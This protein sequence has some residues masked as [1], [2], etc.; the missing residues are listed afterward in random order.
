MAKVTPCFENG[1]I[2]VASNLAQGIGFGSSELFVFRAQEMDRD[3]LFYFLQ[4]PR[5]I[6][7]CAS[8]MVGTGGLKRISTTYLMRYEI[9]LPPKEEQ[10]R[11]SNF[12]KQHSAKI[13]RMMQ[14]AQHLIDQ[15]NEYKQ[16]LITEKVTKGLH[17]EVAR[18]DSG[19]EW[20]GEIPSSWNKKRLKFLAE[21]KTGPFGTQLKATEYV[22]EG[23]PC[24]NV[25]N[26]GYGS[27]KADDFDFVP[28]SVIER[29]SE[30][31]LQEGDIVFARK[32]SIDKHAIITQAESGW[33]QGSDCIRVRLQTDFDNR[34]FNYYLANSGLKYYLAS[35][36]NGATMASLNGAMIENLLILMPPE[37]EQ[38]EIAAFLDAKCAAI[39]A[40]ITKRRKLIDELSE[41][42]RSLIY[43]VVTGK[44]EVV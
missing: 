19:V 10:K 3:Y 15:L 31:I 7:D 38:H 24:I 23:T 21:V 26:I 27:I 30:H 34:F 12:L 5:F 36:S 2:A 28:P 13:D 37:K 20:I 18:K 11:R 43:E 25:K 16:S 29:L 35:L 22:T 14:R 33:L 6:A 42:K 41:Y 39:D 9:P 44:R 4:N 1:E 32:G 8:T 17:P 40:K